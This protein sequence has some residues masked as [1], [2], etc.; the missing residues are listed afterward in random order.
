MVFSAF[1]K[2]LLEEGTDFFTRPRIASLLETLGKTEAERVLALATMLRNSCM[3]ELEEAAG[4]FDRRLVR[5]AQRQLRR[6][7]SEQDRK[8][9]ASR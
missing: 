9:R 1:D 6:E 3:E 4:L 5:A 8:R 2:R 7:G